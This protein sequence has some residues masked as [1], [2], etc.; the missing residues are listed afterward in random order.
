MDQPMQIVV[1]GKSMEA[2]DGMTLSGFVRSL[3]FD[4]VTLVADH[5]G[6]IV[7]RGEFDDRTLSPGDRLELVR[8]VG[9]G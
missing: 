4:P 2:E 9:G 8:L 6:E 3:G 1:N 5:N 7:P